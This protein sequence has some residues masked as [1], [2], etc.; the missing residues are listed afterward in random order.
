MKSSRLLLP[1][2]LAFCIHAASA[3]T[4]RVAP[5]GKDGGDGAQ[6]TF[7]GARDAVRKARDAGDK[8]GGK[9]IFSE[10]TY[11]ITEPV[12]FEPR[13]SGVSYEAASGAKVVI[14][15]GR[16]I[17]GAMKDG[18][19]TAKVDPAW[20]FEGLWVNGERATRARTPNEGFI[21]AMG[22][23]QKPPGD[24]KPTGDAGKTMLA[25]EPQY[26]KELAGLSAEERRDVNVNV[27][28][29]WDM[30]RH[31]LENADADGTLQFTGPLQREFFSL[32]PFHNLR[33]ENYRAALDAPGEWFLDRA[34]TLFYIPRKGE[35]VADVWAPVAPQWIVM[36]GDAAKDEFVSGLTF[37]GLSFQHQAWVTPDGG[38][39]FGQA[40]SKL[41]SAIETDGARGITFED[42]EFA[43]TMTYAAWFRRGC[44][45][46]TLRKCNIHDLGAGGV[47]VGD[48]A[49]AKDGPDHT[50]HVLVDNC[51]IQSGG[52]V[53]PAGIGALI[54]HAS[55]CTLRHCDIAD[56]FYSSVSIGWTWGYKPTPCARNTVEF[57]HLYHLGWAELSDMGAV[58]TLGPQ[59][60][61]IIRGCHMHDIGCASYGGWGMYNDEGSTGIVW[62]NNLVHD[63]QDGGYHQHYGRGNIIRNNIFAFQKEV[64]IRRSK[65]EEFLAFAFEQNIVLFRE[66][67]LFGHVDKNWFDGRVHLER[68]VYWKTGGETFSLAGKTWDEWRN[69]GNDVESVIADPL[70]IA[71]EKGDYT[72]RP[73]SPALKLGFKPFD[74]RLAGVTGDDAWKKIAARE[75]GP[76]KY[77]IKPK[78]PAMNLAEGFE[79]TAIGGKPSRAQGHYKKGPIIAV[80]GEGASK[81]ARCLQLTDG[82]DI[83]PAFEP[84]FYYLPNHERG[85]TRVAFDV[86]LEPGYHFLHEWRDNTVT[87]AKTYQSGPMIEFKN[88][89]LSSGGR[90]LAAFPPNVWLHVELSAKIG[91]GRDN[92]F[93]L[94]LTLP[95]QPPQRFEKLPCAGTRM[96]KLD[97]VGF[98]SPG[99]EAAKC[100][101]DEIVIEN[102]AQE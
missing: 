20:R 8:S 3:L 58:Y 51:I 101:L 13:D 38:A 43:H 15:G 27:Y 14:T 86:K 94:T 7:A 30:A 16:K 23:P 87:G 92:T 77:G 36:R 5:D 83:E 48:P 79:G 91:D 46:I 32:A 18:M 33:L 11:A 22:Q 71:P 95:G 84:H 47:K 40:E 96:E 1:S 99:K 54:F 34:G 72:L 88:G 80:V 28:F 49:V 66:G 85:I 10:G 82:P 100:W 62:E 53:F 31:R 73:E 57:C 76:M 89:T 4:V 12:I 9:V 67:R 19:W 90:K 60:G 44:S 26:A 2:I 74:W 41:I 21:Q 59:P 65:P 25:I 93:N 81:G 61:T 45:D 17:T 97:W 35:T 63:T 102:T 6:A 78:A 75:F 52:R 37:R 39:F 24:A 69:F 29:S 56:F 70:F 50:H 64:Q 68:N 98:I 42:C 55:D